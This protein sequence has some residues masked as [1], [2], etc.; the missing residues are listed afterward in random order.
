MNYFTFSKE[1]KEF[2][3][4]SLNDIRKLSGKVYPHRMAEWQTKGYVRRIANGMYVFADAPLDELHSG[5]FTQS[6]KTLPLG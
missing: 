4:F 2:P 3:V 6:F 5:C 1:L